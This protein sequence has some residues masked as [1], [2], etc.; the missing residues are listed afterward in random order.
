MIEFE[1]VLANG[2]I[3]TA[4]ENQHSDIFWALRGGGNNFGVVISVTIDVFRDPPLLYALQRWDI[5][6]L[7]SV[8]VRLY[9]LTV[10]MPKNMW[11]LATTLAW[12]PRNETMIITERTLWS[13]APDLPRAL[14]SDKAQ[15]L[16]GESQV[17]DEVVNQR[18]ILDISMKMDR[19]NPVGFYNFFGSFTFKNDVQTSLAVADIFG[20][21]VASIKSAK[22]LQVYI[23]YNP[24]TVETMSKMSQRGGNALGLTVDGGP[25]IILNINLHWSDNSDEP[26]MRDFM[27]RMTTRMKEAAELRGTHHP[28]R[29]QNHAFEEQ[30]I[31]EGYGADNFKRLREVRK[32]VDPDGIFQMLQPGYFK[33]G[34]EPTESVAN[35]KSEL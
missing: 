18:D 21:E 14:A 16:M 9:D 4:T 25:L 11:M 35:V 28:Y 22:G 2:T 30:D 3:L 7:N 34:L 15:A 24:L 8:F 19:W 29:F 10:Q 5:A 6:V 13:E 1:V 23:V 12:D 32:S 20:E 27:R 17:L 31:F 33:L 26:R